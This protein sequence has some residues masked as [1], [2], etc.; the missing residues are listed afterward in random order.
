MPSLGQKPIGEMEERKTM[1]AWKRTLQDEL[2]T[3]SLTWEE[4]K[5]A[6]KDRER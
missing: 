4:A 6:A 2:K 3:I 5:K 1:I